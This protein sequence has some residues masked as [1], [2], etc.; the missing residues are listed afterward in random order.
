MY[1]S[2]RRWCVVLTETLSFP[3]VPL[4]PAFY[5]L[6]YNFNIVQIT[7]LSELTTSWINCSLSTPHF[8][9]K[10]QEYRLQPVRTPYSI[11]RTIER[12]STLIMQWEPSVRSC[13]HAL[14][15][16]MYFL[17]FQVYKVCSDTF[18]SYDQH[19]GRGLVNDTIKDGMCVFVFLPQVYPH[20]RDFDF[21]LPLTV[22]RGIFQNNSSQIYN[23][24]YA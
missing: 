6:F 24:M 19:Y 16:M 22:R 8:H 23:H 11:V 18:D 20:L 15:Y 5:I 9:C 7:H 2:S 21:L 3:A 17:L 14:S 12:M 1:S 10:E 13:K 4:L